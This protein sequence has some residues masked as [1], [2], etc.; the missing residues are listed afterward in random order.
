MY[1]LL[2]IAT[3][4]LASVFIMRACLHMTGQL[5]PDLIKTSRTQLSVAEDTH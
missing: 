4:N 3:Y 2:F 5:V 1:S